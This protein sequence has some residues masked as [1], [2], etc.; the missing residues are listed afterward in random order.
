MPGIV[1]G[2]HVLLACLFGRKKDVD[3]RNKSGND[4][5]IGATEIVIA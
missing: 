3:G 2:T 4:S 1:P 5:E